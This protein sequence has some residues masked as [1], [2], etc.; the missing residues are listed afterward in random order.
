[1]FNAARYHFADF[2]LEACNNYSISGSPAFDSSV[3]MYGRYSDRR[4][5]YSQRVDFRRH[6]RASCH[7]PG[8]P[9][10]NNGDRHIHCIHLRKVLHN[11]TVVIIGPPATNPGARSSTME[12]AI[13]TSA[14][15]LNHEWT[16]AGRCW[17][18]VG[19]P[20]L[21]KPAQKQISEQYRAGA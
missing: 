7:K 12:I 10:L 20:L 21:K 3:T 5:Q 2:N 9:V 18:T 15:S 13:S 19:Q 6:N 11:V 1:M 17:G 16:A 4:G 8:G 14:V